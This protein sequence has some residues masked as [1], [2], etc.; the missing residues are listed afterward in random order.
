MHAVCIDTQQKATRFGGTVAAKDLRAIEAL[1]KEEYTLKGLLHLNNIEKDDIPVV[2]W[3]PEYYVR[4]FSDKRLVKLRCGL[5]TTRNNQTKQLYIAG[6]IRDE[7]LYVVVE[8]APEKLRDCGALAPVR[9]TNITGALRILQ[10]KFFP[11]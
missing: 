9:V 8:P 4:K 3:A 5:Y 1:S 7:E 10:K 2:I 6:A 11:K